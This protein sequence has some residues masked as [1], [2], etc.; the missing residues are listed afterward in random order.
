MSLDTLDLILKTGIVDFL[1]AGKGSNGW[2]IHGNHT[3]TGKPILA[4]D[5]HLNNY[6]PAIWS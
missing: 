6:V 5:P 4:N 1:G 2:V 3:T